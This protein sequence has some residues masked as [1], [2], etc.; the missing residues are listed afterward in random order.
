MITELG[1]TMQ[2]FLIEK[3]ENLLRD[4]STNTVYCISGV[5]FYIKDGVETPCKTCDFT[6]RK[7]ENGT[8]LP[9]VH[10]RRN[11]LP[12]SAIAD[13]TA[14]LQLTPNQEYTLMRY[15]EEVSEEE[16]IPHSEIVG[17]YTGSAVKGQVTLKDLLPDSRY[18]LFIDDGKGFDVEY[19]PAYEDVFTDES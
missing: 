14:V 19:T 18:K 7:S 4:V 2:L 12:L 10:Y 6:G 15:W 8:D 1:R 9:D 13:G 3:R 16:V 5:Y 11:Y 17:T